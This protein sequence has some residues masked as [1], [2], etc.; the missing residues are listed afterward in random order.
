MKKV[1]YL[2]IILILLAVLAVPAMAKSP[3][4]NGNGNGISGGKSSTG[5]TPVD[6][7]AGNQANHHNQ[8]NQGDKG[9][10]G[11]RGQGN[12]GQTHPNTPFYLQGTIKSVDTGAKTVTVTLTH[13]NA[14]VKQFIGMDLT[15][16]ATVATQI[17]KITQGVDN[18]SGGG[19]STTPVLSSSEQNSGAESESSAE[20]ENDEADGEKSATNVLSSSE[21]TSSS[22]SATSDEG[23][24]NRV[25]I[26][27]DQLAAGQEVAIHGYLVNGVYTARLITV[28]IQMP[29][30][31]S[32]GE[33]P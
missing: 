28:Y 9:N 16:K 19:E 30:G 6:Q 26:P 10:N 29:V 18:E 7:I 1:A 20:G 21:S 24:S 25:A 3:H 32:A 5:E 15:I 27:F 33:Q 12:K 23:D 22:E 2:G 4:N 14:M 11:A 8:H 31:E 17:Y 13:G